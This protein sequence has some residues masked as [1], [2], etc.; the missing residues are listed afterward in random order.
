MAK[1]ILKRLILAA[2]LTSAMAQTA[3]SSKRVG[4]LN[5]VITDS[6][7]AS[8]ADV[9]I[10]LEHWGTDELHDPKLLNELV[11]RTD[12]DGKYTIELDPGLYDLFISTLMFSPVAK[13]IR[14]E[15]GKT[16]VFSPKLRLDRLIQIIE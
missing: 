10:R 1:L 14:I 13:K 8:V 6:T 15:A 5:G 9:L 12:G 11:V 4:I 7:G 3:A 2:L 16:S